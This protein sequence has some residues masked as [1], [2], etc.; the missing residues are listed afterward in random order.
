[1]SRTFKPEEE[2][3]EAMKPCWIVVL[4]AAFVVTVGFGAPTVAVAQISVEIPLT[5]D[6]EAPV[7]SSAG[8]GTFRG[9]LSA[10][11]T[12]VDYELTYTLTG[13]V[14]QGHIHLAQR[15]V[16]GGI[17]VWL[18]QTPANVDPTGLS[19]Q[20]PP[21]GTPVTGSF[22]SANVIGPAN[23]GI[24]P[25]EFAEVVTAMADGF[26]YVNVHS[27]ICPSG[28]VRGQIERP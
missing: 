27:D 1:V 23:Q 2:R 15:E 9:T 14:T 8:S 13:T 28:E 24:A 18:C 26:T 16:S 6:E 11:Q 22:T 12:T 19:P 3:G 7:C 21:S 17:I 10:D 5:P 20:C 25:G 4:L